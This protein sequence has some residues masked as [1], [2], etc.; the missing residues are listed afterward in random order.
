MPVH[1]GGLQVDHVGEGAGHGGEALGR[2][3]PPRAWFRLEDCFQSVG[4]GDLGEEGCAVAAE[5][6]ADPGVEPGT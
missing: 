1:A 4:F 6:F 3:E 5:R 2:V